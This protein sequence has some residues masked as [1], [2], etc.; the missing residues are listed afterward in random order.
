MTLAAEAASRNVGVYVELSTGNVYKSSAKKPA[1]EE[2]GKLKPV[3]KQAKWKLAVEE[4]LRKL[5]SEKGDKKLNAV[6]LRLA[7]VYGPYVT[8][9][10][11]QALCLARVCQA[12]ERDEDKKMRWLWGEDLRTDTVHVEDVA[13]ALWTVAEWYGKTPAGKRDAMPVFNIVDQ[14]QTSKLSVDH[15]GQVLMRSS[16]RNSRWHHT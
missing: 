9:F 16:T 14:G 12:E 10:L 7:N 5:C 1:T 8:R 13:S 15:C 4:D 2:S 3:T 11:G 6:V